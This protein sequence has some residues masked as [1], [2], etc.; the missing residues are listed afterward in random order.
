ML[1]FDFDDSRIDYLAEALDATPKQVKMA[2]NR[3]VRRTAGTL[4]RMASTGIKTE[5]GLRNVTALRRRIKE[6]RVGKG[7]NALKLWFG[8]NDLPISAFP[9][10]KKQVPGGVQVGDIMIHGGFVA[11]IRG[12]VGV[13]TRHGRGRWAISEA[14]VPVADRIMIYLEDNV[15]VDIDSIFWK[16]FENEIHAYTILKV[17]K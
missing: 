11:K 14:T 2:T 5:L 6:Y 17:G 3:A 7:G 13:Y 1:Q 10:R 9:G 8:T 16:H 12:K 15:F 4:R